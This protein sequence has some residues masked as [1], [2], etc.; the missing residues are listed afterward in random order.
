MRLS[1]SIRCLFLL[2]WLLLS[3]CRSEGPANSP[4]A[5]AARDESPC[6]I[7]DFGIALPRTLRETSGLALAGR[8]GIVWSHNDSGNA[9]VVYAL[10]DAGEV[11][12][13]VRV[14]GADNVDWEAIAATDCGQAR[15]LIVGDIGDNLARRP[16]ITFYRFPEPGPEAAE[17]RPALSFHARYPGGPRDGEAL[18]VS[19]TGELYVIN[20]GQNDPVVLYRYPGTPRENETVT[21]EPVRE[22]FPEATDNDDYITGAAVSPDGRWTAVRSY[23][24]LY[25]YRT[26]QLTGSGE[27]EPRVFDLAPVSEPQGE[28]VAIADD[29]TVWLTSEAVIIGRPV[30]ARLHCELPG[31][32]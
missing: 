16:R 6:R 29:G 18:F 8:P 1:P 19:G 4:R 2:A 5:D 11:V 25:L 27:A 24:H 12:Q 30:I 7:V 26:E 32:R 20:K 22:L 14:A 13:T 17:S 9:P 3:A 10:T 23:R 31:S 15:C 21:L 28:A